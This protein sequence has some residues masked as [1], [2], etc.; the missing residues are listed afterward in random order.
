MAGSGKNN[1]KVS[2]KSN[3]KKKEGPKG[4][5]N[6][7]MFFSMENRDKIKQELLDSLNDDEELTGKEI[8]AEVSAR[9]KALKEKEKEKYVLMADEDK[10]RY[11][12]QQEQWEKKGYW[13]DEETGEKM[14]IKKKKKDDSDEESDDEDDKENKGK[15]NKN[16]DKK[17]DDKVD[18]TKD[19]KN[20]DTKGK[21]NKDKEKE[22]EDQKRKN[23]DKDKKKEQEDKKDES[24]SDAESD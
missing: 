11:E 20:K 4:K 18:K 23:K 16:Q 8:T 17:K 7:Y 13:I 15:S 6:A 3:T 24:N 21:S 9:Y 22:K 2:N 12:K 5:K 10:A 1:S 14:G 19:T